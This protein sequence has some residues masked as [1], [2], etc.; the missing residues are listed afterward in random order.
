MLTDRLH[1]ALL[2][3][4]DAPVPEWIPLIPASPAGRDGRSWPQIDADAIAA[5]SLAE[6]EMI[7][8]DWEHSTELRAPK[9]EEAPASGWV[10]ALENRDGALWGKIDWT[11]RAAAQIAGREYRFVSP[12]ILFEPDSRRIRRLSGVAL[13]NRPNFALPA[14]NAKETFMSLT[15]LC[16]AL[17][18]DTSSTEAQL[19]E[20]I[21]GMK[22]ELASAVNRAESPPL[23]RFIPR[24]DY[25]AALVRA[26]NA[27]QALAS[28][29]SSKLGADV[30]AV[31][32]EAMRAGKITPATK[33]F[34]VSLCLAENGSRLPEFRKFLEAMPIVVSPAPVLAGAAN[35][36]SIPVDGDLLKAECS[37]QW[38]SDPGLHREFGSMEIFLAY[39]R[40]IDSGRAKIFG[41]PQ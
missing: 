1:V 38:A 16:T 13:T 41:S 6:S 25:D 9:G 5:E 36:I 15:A 24:A 7:P 26:T 40:A 27:E 2:F 20:K 14:L 4:S 39:R 17:N 28:E 32:G 10:T 35:S 29:R 8:V 12:T 18:V 21:T 3:S 33:D 30:D 11:P 34:Y 37:R 31:I 22:A 23:E 19:V